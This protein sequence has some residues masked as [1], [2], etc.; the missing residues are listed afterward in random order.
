MKKLNKKKLFFIGLLGLISFITIAVF[1]LFWNKVKENSGF[2]FQPVK[3]E[4]G[5]LPLNNSADLEVN[6]EE[7]KGLPSVGEVTQYTAS[8][9]WAQVIF[10]PQTHRYP[11]SEVGDQVNNSAEIAQKQIY[12]ILSYAHDNTGINFV[13]VEGD[14]YG[15]SQSDEKTSEVVQK[16]SLRNSLV[17]QGEKIKENITGSY[18]EKFSNDLSA[19]IAL[20]DR[21]IILKGP[22]Y[23]LKAQ[24]DNLTI[25]GSE[26][27]ATREK[28]T[29]VARDYIYLQDRKAQL[30]NRGSRDQQLSML[31]NL[32]L[33]QS[34]GKNNPEKSV[35]NDIAILG[36][37][38]SGAGKDAISR[39]RG[40][41]NELQQLHNSENVSDAS[42]PNR[43]D[44][45]YSN[46]T[47]LNEI[48]SRMQEAE[49]KVEQQIIEVRNKETAENFAKALKDQNLN[50][51]MLQFGAGHTE[52]LVAELNKLGISVIVVT[53]KEVMK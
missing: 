43:S 44:N 20:L 23:L 45:P 24:G 14:L 51:G 36:G 28:S 27:P 11:G 13:M 12:D 4:H 46:V 38:V 48:N 26:N 40:T 37:L 9:P 2:S 35:R 34:Q 1:P 49:K 5:I 29:L 47:S 3:A 30:E 10:I 31:K 16:L 33:S 19:L 8:D 7:F 53:P 22:A 17:E 21:E 42:V 15:S 25:F 52:G 39:F 18:Q 41:L 32:Y 50:I 6:I